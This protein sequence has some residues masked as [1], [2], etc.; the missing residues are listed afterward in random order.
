MRG[1]KSE[2]VDSIMRDREG[3]KIDL[4]DSEVFTG[5]D[6]FHSI[7]ERGSSLARLVARYIEILAEI[8]VASLGGDIN[9]TVNRSQQYSQAARMIA[10]FVSNQHGIKA[11]NVLAYDREPAGNLFSAQTRVYKNASF[12]R[13]EQ[14]RIT[15]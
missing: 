4:A 9:R 13:N 2:V 1:S 7:A 15:S 11:M 8:R 5:F 3:M 14:N 10:V 12:T 6:L